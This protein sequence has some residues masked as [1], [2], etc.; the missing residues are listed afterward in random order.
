MPPVLAGVLV[1]TGL[2]LVNKAGSQAQTSRN[3]P[4]AMSQIDQAM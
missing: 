2:I 3:T 1:V 4:S